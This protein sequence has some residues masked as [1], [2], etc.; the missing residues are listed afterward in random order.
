M[1]QPLLTSLLHGF[2]LLQHPTGKEE[3]SAHEKGLF[4]WEVRIN[5]ILTEGGGRAKV[6]GIL[7]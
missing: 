1:Q 4:G 6:T 3:D 7:S 5:K 2:I